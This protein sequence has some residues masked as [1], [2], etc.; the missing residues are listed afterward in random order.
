VLIL[1]APVY[2]TAAVWIIMSMMI[3][4]ARRNADRPPVTPPG[5]RPPAAE[6]SKMEAAYIDYTLIFHHKVDPELM[7]IRA[8]RKG[9]RLNVHCQVKKEIRKRVVYESG[10]TFDLDFT[11]NSKDATPDIVLAAR[12]LMNPGTPVSTAAAALAIAKQI[13]KQEKIDTGG[14]PIRAEEGDEFWH[15][16]F[17][18]PGE[19]STVKREGYE[20]E[21]N[22][23]TGSILISKASGKILLNTQFNFYGLDNGFDYFSGSRKRLSYGRLVELAPAGNGGASADKSSKSSRSE[24]P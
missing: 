7:D 12:G 9:D 10:M 8:E 22:P 15:F 4:D 11:F 1:G 6:L 3:R 16:V 13:V 17:T 2:A 19:E 23:M 24:R 5:S 18:F 21:R 14:N 20:V